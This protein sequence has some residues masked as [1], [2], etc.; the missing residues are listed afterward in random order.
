M[1]T[2]TAQAQEGLSLALA[3]GCSSQMQGASVAQQPL[4]GGAQERAEGE[5]SGGGKVFRTLP[6]P[7]F[8]ATHHFLQ[9]WEIS[10]IPSSLSKN[11]SSSYL[12]ETRTWALIMFEQ[13]KTLG[14]TAQTHREISQH[15]DTQV[16]SRVPNLA[17]FVTI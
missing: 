10:S 3:G 12:S 4:P 17:L 7:L 11:P 6:R 8:P 13:N 5:V 2:V 14:H 15:G 1:R 9:A 16:S